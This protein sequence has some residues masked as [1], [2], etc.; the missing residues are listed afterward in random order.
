MVMTAAIIG[1]SAGQASAQI[2]TWT[3]VTTPAPDANNGGMIV[4][5]NG[6]LFLHSSSGGTQGDGT[7]WDILTPDSTGSYI[8]GTWSQS[9]PMNQERFSFSSEM[10]MSGNIYVAGGEYGTDGT[11]AGYH[12]EVY[13][14]L[15]NVW[16]E[17]TGTNSTDIISDGSCKLLDNGDVIQALVDVSFPVHCR[18]YTPGTNAMTTAP[19]TLHGSNESMWLKLPDN[20]VLMVD[21]G[22]VSSERY[23]PSLGQWVAD[24]IVPDSLYDPYGYECGPGWMLPDGRAF[25]IG[26]TSHTAFYTP[27]GNNTPGSWGK[28]PEVPN[29]YGMPDAPGVMMPNGHILFACSP[30]PTQQ[31]EFASPTKFYEFNYLDSSYTLVPA[32]DAGAATRSIC[33][34]YQM[35]M[36]PNGQVLLGLSADSTSQTYYIYT[37]GSGPLAAGKPIINSIDKL[38][39]TTFMATG[40]GFNGISEGAAFGDENECDSNYPIFRFT[41]GGKVYYARSYNWNSAGVQRGLSNIDTAYFELPPTMGTG[42]YELYVVANGI[43]SDSLAFSDSIPNLSSS[44]S[45]PSICTGTA[46]TYTGTSGAPGA[47]LSWTRPAVTGISNAAVTTPQS[48]GINEV[49]TNTTSNPVTVNYIYEVT[50]Y[51]CNNNIS[52][53]VVVNPVPTAAFVA[54]PISAC[55]LPDSVTFINNSIAGTSYVWSFGDGGTSTAANP[56]YGYNTNGS[57]TVKL[58]ASSACGVDSITQAG[59]IAVTAPAGPTVS[60]GICGDSLLVFH[61]G[62]TSSGVSWFDSLGN[63][64]SSANPFITSQLSPTTY[65]AQ[66]SVIAP[67]DSVGPATYSTLGGGGNFAGSNPH[68]MIFDAQADLTIISVVVDASVAGG[69]T[70]SLYDSLGNMLAVATPTVPAGVSTVPLNFF[71]PK[72]TSYGLVGG[73]GNNAIN[74]YRNNAVPAG[75]YPFT[76]PNLISIDASDVGTGRYYFFYDWYV[77]GTPCISART[78]VTATVGGCTGITPVP[79]AMSFAVYPNPAA[80]EVTVDLHDGYE[81]ATVSLRDVLGQVLTTR[82]ASGAQ[83]TLDLSSYTD[84]IYFVEVSQGGTSAARKLVISR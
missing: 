47:T 23:I 3:K 15:T 1:L 64:V 56:V 22:S 69:Q 41:S 39:C 46:F 57:Y 17:A 24:G 27:S 83:I 43:A 21:E 45:P 63:Y 74:L 54:A 71:V 65:Y 37:P 68:Y 66:D 72:G 78:P 32:P 77:E 70:I 55:I 14:P 34:Q 25:F 80:T 20:S 67:V 75:S 10:L 8:N 84:G 61:A 35:L 50:A 5:S 6:S 38:T 76:I 52:V 31:N 33:Q 73:D 82:T 44:L 59:Y 58:V 53:P 81:G 62:T 28:G 36:L 48:S 7:I 42:S 51:G 49:L 40:H 19:S 11:Q 26:G 16:T 4:M 30:Q 13:N 12:V 29:G 60:G 9:A 2:G 18:F 79:A